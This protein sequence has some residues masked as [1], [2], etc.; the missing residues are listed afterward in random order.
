VLSYVVRRLLHSVV[1]LVAASFLVFTF[2][3]VSGDPLAQLNLVPNLSEQSRQNVIESKHLDEP[4]PVRYAYWVK[5]A[6]TNQF[7]TTLQGD[8]PILP[9]LWRVMKNT[10]QLVFIAEVL[11]ILVAVGIGVYSARRQYSAFDY[12]ATTVSF[13]GLATPVFWLALM[14]QVL[15]VQIYEGTGVRLFPIASLSS[16]DP[17]TGIH[18]VLDRAH[19]L[20]LPVLVLM[21]ASVASY[22]RYV[23]A[24]MLEV[25]N[26]DYVR[27]ARAKGL[28]EKRVTMKH[29]FRNALIPLVT[30]VALSFGNLLGG[31]IVVETVFSLDGMGRYFYNA[32]LASDPYPVMAWLM[33]T[34]TLIIVF[35]LFADIAYAYLDPRVR[36]E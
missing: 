20:A 9:D 23:R 6:V 8:R 10:L 34:A 16:V 36:Y 15:V 27:T 11:S 29:A 12:T 19:H 26:A 7:G 17:G 13:L 25:L 5:D 32:L 31:V 2:V 4:I 22:S 21:V 3:S 24:S 28:S 1:V 33:V 18:F 14:L 30:L 35:N